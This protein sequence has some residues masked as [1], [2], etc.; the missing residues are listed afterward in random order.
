MLNHHP[1]TRWLFGYEAQRKRMLKRA[2]EGPL[3]DF[4]SVPFPPLYTPLNCIP[5]LAVDFETTGLDAVQ[6]KLLSVGCVE[7]NFNQIKLGSSYHQIINA[8]GS[9]KANNVTIHQITDDQKDQGQPLAEVIEQLLKR[10]AGKVMLVHFARIERQF[11]R[12]ACLELYGMAPPFPII[13]TLVVAKRR[14]D[15]RDVAYDPSELRLLAL[16]EKYDLPEHYAHNAL[17]DAIATAELLLA[18]LSERSK[19]LS[20]QQLIL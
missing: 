5:I 12:Q 16:R 1:L 9:L 18:Q 2:P 6:D 11:L 10:L 15:K 7:L 13:D 8:K 14:L 17:N 3:R 4:L 20:L 19:D